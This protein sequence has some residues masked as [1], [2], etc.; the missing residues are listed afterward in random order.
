MT[1]RQ[2]HCVAMGLLSPDHAGAVSE[3]EYR[4]LVA[5]RP[6]SED[7]APSALATRRIR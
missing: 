5:G 3:I 2:R 7:S 4:D 1:S 6:R